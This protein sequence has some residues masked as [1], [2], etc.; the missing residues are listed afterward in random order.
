M[1]PRVEKLA[2]I[3][4]DYSVGVRKGDVV[5]VGADVDGAPLA[6]AVYRRV[7]QRGGFPRLRVY[8]PEV[9]RIYFE[10]AS[11]EQLGTLLPIDLDEYEAS[12]CLI[13]ISAP[14]NLAETA[15]V[16]PGKQSA[17]RRTMKPVSDY[18][19][20]GK[21]RWCGCNFPCN[22]LAQKAEMSLEEY[23]DFVYGAT[24]VDWAALSREQEA[25]KQLFDGGRQVHLIGE[26]TDLTFSIEGRPG[27]NC[28]GHYNMPDGEVFYSPVEDSAEGYI[29]FSYPA[30]YMD[31]EVEG[32]RLTFSQGKVVE[33]RAAK[34]EEFLLKMLDTDPGARR[35]G[36][37]GIG[38]NHGITKFTRDILFDE[39]IGGTIHLALGQSYPEAKGENDSAIHWD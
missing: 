9:T 6:K 38:T 27:V 30:I 26:G 5:M 22:A 2:E 31:R 28:D 35:I 19:M 13:R 15:N 11:D 24:N 20:A 21:V 16:D 36:E 37:F 14:A 23:E 10:E 34:N 3:L 25:I 39:K 32:V 8:L 12:Q 18:V 33:A 7:L 29:T 4:V 1:D 17:R